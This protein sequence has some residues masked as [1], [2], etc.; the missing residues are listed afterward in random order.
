MAEQQTKAEAEAAYIQS[1]VPERQVPADL[2]PRV[3]R[4]RVT[5]DVAGEFAED[6]SLEDAMTAAEA[7]HS[8][9]GRYIEG[10]RAV[11]SDTTMTADAQTLALADMMNVEK[12]PTHRA[13]QARQRLSEAHSTASKRVD[14]TIK[15]AMPETEAQELRSVVRSMSADDREK[16]LTDLRER[17]DVR[18]LAALVAH[19]SNVASGLG[20]G[21]YTA[22]RRF[23][24]QKLAPAEAQRRDQTAKARE[25]LD[26]LTELY[27]RETAA[28][29]PDQKRV[30][31]I[32]SAQQASRKAR[33]QS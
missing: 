23:V 30:S 32:R 31:R 21:E 9:L 22:T 2:D 10:E 16:L 1:N 12:G 4:A 3:L 33:G 8:Q 20:P 24:E 29:T 5:G 19:P 15:S 26:S 18:S 6:P 11:K 28:M 14:Q 25:Q 13:D 7:L 27:L 17:G